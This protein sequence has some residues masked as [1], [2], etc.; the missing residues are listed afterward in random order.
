MSD[1]DIRFIAKK[2][3]VSPATVSRVIN[4][5]KPVS[6]ALRQQVMESIIRYRYRPN[7]MAKSLHSR[8][9]N[10]IGVVTPTVSGFFHARLLLGIEG[11]ARRRGYHVLVSNLT[12]GFE[13][14]KD[15]FE[16]LWERR[17]DGILLAH[18]NT[19]EEFRL[20]QGIAGMPAVFASI[21]I[22]GAG[23]PCVCVDD[24]Q[25]AYDMASLLIRLGHK[26]IGGIFND[27]YSLGVLRRRGFENALRD[28]GIAPRPEWMLLAD[29]TFAS[30]AAAAGQM[31]SGRQWPSA[32]FCVS[33]EIAIGAMNY[34]MDAGFGIPGDVSVTGF[35]GIELGEL[36]RP[37]LTTVRQP[38][39]EIGAAAASMLADLLEGGEKKP[40]ELGERILP[41]RI[42]V[43]ESTG[44]IGAKK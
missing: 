21:H 31:F 27:C 37:R 6:P 35:D 8:K 9:S 4:G 30:G 41:Y 16:L 20:L 10:L 24:E 29:C 13:Q 7:L 18:E 38:I 33:D 40:G 44:R 14:E 3:G 25:A 17:V 23:V 11:E 12:E 26:E 43:R 32:L 1:M 2:A 42:L 22:P 28:N 15:C 19:L 5:S 34:L 39:E 36:I